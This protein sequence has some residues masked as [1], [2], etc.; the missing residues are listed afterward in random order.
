MHKKYINT[1][2]HDRNMQGKVRNDS[3]WIAVRKGFTKRWPLRWTLGQAEDQQTDK[4]GRVKDAKHS[5]LI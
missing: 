3:I 2:Y 5:Q 1:Q 4:G